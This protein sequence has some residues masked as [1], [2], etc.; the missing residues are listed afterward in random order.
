MGEFDDPPFIIRYLPLI[1]SLFIVTIILY[2]NDGFSNSDTWI[3]V[4]I[5]IVI[6][7]LF[8]IFIYLLCS[9]GYIITAWF[10]LVIIIMV[11]TTRIH[12]ALRLRSSRY[13]P[14][15]EW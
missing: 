13:P 8:V 11:L 15:Y 3:T 7:M 10:L 12:S 5:I 4:L 2:L 9:N 1:I 6:I 14:L